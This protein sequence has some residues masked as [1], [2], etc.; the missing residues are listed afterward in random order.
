MTRMAHPFL[1]LKQLAKSFGQVN[2]LGPLDFDLAAGEVLGLV[3]ENGAGKSTLIKLLSGVYRPNQGQIRLGGNQVV[4]SSPRVALDF[5]FATIHQEL[6]Y[7]GTLTVAE[8]MLLGEPWPRTRWQSVDWAALHTEA[9]RRLAEF[10]LKIS[11]QRLF[12]SLSPAEKQ[13]VALANAVAGNARLLILDEPTA[14][15]TEPEVDRLFG[16]LQRL[17]RRGVTIIYVSHRLDEITQITDRVAV[18]RDGN[19][20]ATYT[21]SAVDAAQ[22]LQDMIGHPLEQIYPR[23]RSTEPGH[24]LLELH[25]LCRKNMFQ[26]ISF[27]VHAGEVVGLAGLV[28]SG[29]SELARA[30]FG[31]YGIDQGTMRV[32]GEVWQPRGPHDAIA[33]GL[34]YLPEE[35]KRQGFVLDHSLLES[36][37][38]GFSDLITRWGLVSRSLERAR[39]LE[40]LTAFDIRA[41]NVDQ[42]VGTLSGGNQQKA[43]LARC[44]IREPDILILDEPTR[45]VDVGAKSQIHGT[46]DQL[47]SSGKAILVISSDLQEV[48][49]VCDRVLIMDRGQLRAQLTGD[50]LTEHN[51]ILASSGLYEPD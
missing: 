15:L 13:E 47:A 5:G 51:V 25:N 37:G 36:I 24:P 9:N 2:A 44:L 28:G 48:L 27:R 20:V 43:L 3:G 17:R 4:L 22:I 31:L 14:S 41:Q 23:T 26:D 38:I 21:T 40:A 29:R 49:G 8:N 10:G 35:R 34:V 19:L 1:E 18:L 33:R 45:G 7:C 46:I 42:P 32:R 39:V 12:A 30:I 16:H 50:E 11:A 6:D